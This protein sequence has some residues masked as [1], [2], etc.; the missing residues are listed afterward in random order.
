MFDM[1]LSQRRRRWEWRV[2][3]SSG[4]TILAGLETQRARARYQAHRALFMLLMTIP[5]RELD[6]EDN[7]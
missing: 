5:A 1:V 2:N 3:D 6:R 4:K 7:L